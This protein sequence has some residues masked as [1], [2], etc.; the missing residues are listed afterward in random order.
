MIPVASTNS[1]TQFFYE[2]API[3]PVDQ[4]WHFLVVLL[5]IGLSVAFV[6]FLYVRDSVEL[7]MGKRALLMTLRL[8]AVATVVAFFLNF[9]MKSEQRVVRDSR[10]CV[11]LD[12]SASMGLFDPLEDGTRTTVSRLESIRQWLRQNQL[13]EELSTRHEVEFFT[14]ADDGNPKSMGVIEAGADSKVTRSDL[15]PTDS[16]EVQRVLEQFKLAKQR[17]LISLVV[18]GLFIVSFL[19]SICLILGIFKLSNVTASWIYFAAGLF[20][21][22]TIVSMAVTDLCCVN[23]TLF[24]SLT[25]AKLDASKIKFDETG[26]N[27]DE[28]TPN[29]LPD[30]W[31]DQLSPE[32]SRTLLVE[33]LNSIINQE[34]GG[35]IAGIVVITDGQDNSGGKFESTIVT[36]S[37]ANIPI[38]AIGIGSNLDSKNVR[39]VD[40]KAPAKVIPNDKF[41]VT[42]IVQGFAMENQL[43]DVSLFS[44]GTEAD[45]IEI[46]EGT[47][48]A[49][50]GKDGV[51]VAVEFSLQHSTESEDQKEVRI[52]RI[53]VKAPPTDLEP[54]DNESSLKIEFAKQ[55]T[56]VLLVA[57]GP[58]R[59]YRFLRDYL[60]RDEAV[61]LDVF[62]QTATPGA[63]Q[64]GDNVLTRFPE[65]RDQWYQ[66]DCIVAFDPDWQQLTPEGATHLE[67]WV[68][69]KSG[70]LVVV[71]GPVNTPNWTRQPRGNQVTDIM[72]RLYPVVFYS[73][74]ASSIRLGRFGGEVAYPLEFTQAGRSAEFLW[75]ADSSPQSQDAWAECPGVFGYYAVNEEKPAAE[76]YARFADPE[77]ETSG[78]LPIYMA[79]QFYGS[80]RVYFQASGEMWRNRAINLEYFSTYYGKLIR[81]A[82][83]GRL[84]RESTRGV[85]LVQKERCWLG[86]QIG[87]QAILKDDRDEPL[88]APS[89]TAT[90]LDGSGKPRDLVLKPSEDKT[91][92]GSYMGQ[93]NASEKGKYL[94]SLP[95]DDIGGQKILTKTVQAIVPEWETQKP[96]RNDNDLFVLSERTGGQYFVGLESLRQEGGSENQFQLTPLILPQD[97]ETFLP[98]TINQEFSRRMMVWLLSLIT[99]SLSLEWTI[100]RLNKLA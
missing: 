28:T 30:D 10:V 90:I 59:E 52:F 53:A 91:Q 63:D 16:I 12:T 17:G 86:E 61:T 33:S 4:W 46:S 94:I 29:R 98:G 37:D 66:Y 21:L 22:A 99:M 74:V 68:A 64:E 23:A 95:I 87:I 57:G 89:V 69:E 14:F 58:S 62:L 47:K 24:Q 1:S 19:I 78:V 77:T 7:P 88:I 11:C 56:N 42:G 50:L 38:Y 93:L 6:I 43:V 73:Q 25:Q 36:S 45:A 13:I 20:F 100:R 27:D 8:C 60:Y 92:P 15:E 34:R 2:F 72:R 3:F 26:S 39:I 83:Q 5:A 31:T 65:T 79:S 54:D 49:Q 32:G 35:P 82:S 67:K 41:K 97:Q 80:G 75:L 40:V 55:R 85:L 76:V 81:W 84:A 9:Q 70:G 44:K 48:K 51:P 18:G 71:A 96:K